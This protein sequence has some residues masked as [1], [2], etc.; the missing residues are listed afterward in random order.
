MIPHLYCFVFLLL[1][2]IPRSILR[3]LK[4]WIY[5][6]TCLG[7]CCEVSIV[8]GFVLFLPKYLETQFGTTTSVANLFTG[9]FY[10]EEQWNINHALNFIWSGYVRKLNLQLFTMIVHTVARLTGHFTHSVLCVIVWGE[11]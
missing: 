5:L 2:D 11:G 10:N 7:I 8:S 3:L 4:N 6:I 9:R 1:S